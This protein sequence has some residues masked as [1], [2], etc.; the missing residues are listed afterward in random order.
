MYPRRND[1]IDI[2]AFPLNFHEIEAISPIVST[3]KNLEKIALYYF[4]KNHLSEALSA[5]EMLSEMDT[6]NSE[7]WEKI[8][9]CKQQLA[10]I[11]GAI[12]AYLR[13]ELIDSNNTW[14]LRRI[15]QCY[16]LLKQPKDA[17]LY[18]KKLEK[19]HP[20]DLNVQLNIGHCYLELKEYDK[21]LE[22]YF[23]VEW[24]DD[25]NTRVWRSIAW[26]SFLSHKFDVSQRYYQKILQNNPTSHDF[27]NAGHVELALGNMKE[28][29]SYYTETIRKLKNIKSFKALL[30]GDFKELE[31]SGVD[32]KIIP[33]LLDKIEYDM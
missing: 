32:L 14:V 17:L 6:A 19:L 20:E 11:D 33:A 18:Y 24:I 25:T 29:M 31:L 12:E 23:K 30:R 10:N 13:A 5:Y 7:V 21:A 1:F 4:E 3:P 8:G 26:C 15:A 9:Y 2:F 16:R 28:A 22:N 27:L